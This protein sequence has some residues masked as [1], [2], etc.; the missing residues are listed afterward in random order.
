MQQ[1]DKFDK[2]EQQTLP[3]IDFLWWLQELADTV[4]D[5]EDKDV[6][7]AFWR[8]CAPYIC[9]ELTMQGYEASEITMHE[10]EDFV[11]RIECAH[12]EAHE[13][14]C[15]SNRGGGFSSSG[16]GG[17]SLGVMGSRKQ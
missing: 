16:G 6:V 11:I 3:A 17:G 9:S 5:L 1:R 8:R 14:P 15:S 13:T 10:V 2:Y 7:L 4:G 12:Q